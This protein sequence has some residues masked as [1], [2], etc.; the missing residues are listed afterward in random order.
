MARSA[1]RGPFTPQFPEKYTG[2]YPIIFRSSWELEFMR[3]CDQHPGVMEWASE[4]I[5]IPYQNPLNGKQT[6]YIPDFL[7]TYMNAGGNPSTKLIEIKPMHEAMESHARNGVDVAIRT[8]NEAKWGAATQWAGRRG[9]DFLVLTEA[10]L[11]NN[12]ANRKGRKHAIK[13]KG[14]E[15]LKA[16]NPKG[17]GRVKKQTAKSLATSSRT[18]RAQAKSRVSSKVGK[19]QKASRTPKR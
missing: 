6:V 9:I 1:N 14:K 12:H 19:I 10:E 7:V 17:V 11:Y 16:S 15:Q 13:A 3:Y 4:P 18:A 8:K 5:K 2:T